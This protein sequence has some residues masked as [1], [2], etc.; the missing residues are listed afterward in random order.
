VVRGAARAPGTWRDAGVTVFAR[1]A[2]FQGRFDTIDAGIAYLRDEAVPAILAMQ[3]CV[4]M[5]VLADRKSGLCI[6]TTA[7]QTRDAMHASVSR[8]RPI[9]ERIAKTLGG[10]AEV[11]EWE[12]AVMHRSHG[13]ATAACTRVTWLR[14][15]QGDA[16]LLIDD[17]TAVTLPALNAIRGFCSASLLVNREWGRAA[18][19][20][21]YDSSE[22]MERRPVRADGKREI[23]SS[24]IEVRD[25]DLVMPH[26]RV[27]DLAS[28]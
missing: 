4:G 13:S 10:V 11:E 14:V 24:I 28:Y 25:F 21:A 19:S 5:S 8:I 3:R 22:A 12:V 18:V 27:P 20:V 16:D 26:L 17:F 1:T 2:T 15:E 7:W 23:G 6:A 9:R